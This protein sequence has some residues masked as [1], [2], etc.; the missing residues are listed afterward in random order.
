MNIVYKTP[1][2][3]TP[4]EN[5]PRHNDDAVAAV[6][7]SIKHFGWKVPLV[8]DRDGIIITGHTRYKAALMLGIDRIPCVIADDLTEEQAK[9]FRLA[10]NKTGEFSRW[11]P[12]LLTR[13][14]ADIGIDMAEF[15]V[16]DDSIPSF[17]DFFVEAEEKEHKPKTYTCPCCGKEFELCG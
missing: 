2:E 10:D 7:S 13:E 3:L 4:Y 8:I 16:R 6:A 15:G 12:E 17:D 11:I 14:I 1:D 9:A 5:N